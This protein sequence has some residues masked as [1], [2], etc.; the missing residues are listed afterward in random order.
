MAPDYLEYQWQKINLNRLITA[1]L[2]VGKYENPSDPTDTRYCRCMGKGKI[3]SIKGTTDADVFVP[4][5]I[6]AFGEFTRTGAAQLYIFDENI[7]SLKESNTVSIEITKSNGD[8]VSATLTYSYREESSGRKVYRVNGYPFGFAD[9]V[10]Q[11][12]LM[13]VTW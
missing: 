11:E 4:E 9:L 1:K 5:L 12:V 6:S 13:K 8:I 7:P 10:G 2:T 3:E